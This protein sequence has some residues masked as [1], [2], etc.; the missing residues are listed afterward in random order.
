MHQTNSITDKRHRI[1][2][3]EVPYISETHDNYRKPQPANEDEL[4]I[5]EPG[6]RSESPEGILKNQMF[7]F[8]Y[9]DQEEVELF[10]R[11]LFER[12]QEDQREKRNQ[13]TDAETFGHKTSKNLDDMRKKLN[14]IQSWTAAGMPRYNSRPSHLIMPQTIEDQLKS[15]GFSSKAIIEAAQF[16]QSE[17]DKKSGRSLNKDLSQDL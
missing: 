9:F 14:Q 2:K 15:M 8:N 13:S 6:L 5:I 16:V 4:D 11:K 1:R 12:E 10:K 3:A 17:K 7:L